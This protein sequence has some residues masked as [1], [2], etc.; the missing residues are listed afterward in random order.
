MT[1]KDFYKRIGCVCI[2]AIGLFILFMLFF[3]V[4]A[5]LGA[6]SIPVHP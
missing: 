3:G 2:A 6:S 1:N 5:Y 4:L